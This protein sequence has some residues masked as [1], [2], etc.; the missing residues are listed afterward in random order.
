MILFS[1][2]FLTFA[3]LFDSGTGLRSDVS[4]SDIQWRPATGSSAASA[5]ATATPAAPTSANGAPSRPGKA[6]LDY[7]WPIGRHSSG[8]F[9]NCAAS[10]SSSATAVQAILGTPTAECPLGR[11]VGRCQSLRYSA[12]STSQSTD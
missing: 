4:G 9:S 7:C 12:F 2:E 10:S 11:T 1:A 6:T 8:L 5:T 3:S